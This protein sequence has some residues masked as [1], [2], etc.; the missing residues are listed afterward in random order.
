MEQYFINNEEVMFQK[1]KGFFLDN[2]PDKISIKVCTPFTDTN[3]YPDTQEI[4]SILEDCSLKY[5]ISSKIKSAT[6]KKSKNRLKRKEIYI[7]FDISNI[8]NELV[9]YINCNE[10][11]TRNYHNRLKLHDVELKDYT[12]NLDKKRMEHQ[13]DEIEGKVKNIY[14]QN[15]VSNIIFYEDDYTGKNSVPEWHTDNGCYSTVDDSLFLGITLTNPPNIKLS[16]MYIIVPLLVISEKILSNSKLINEINLIK[17]KISLLDKIKITFY[18][19]N[20]EEEYNVVGTNII[21]LFNGLMD[22]LTSIFLDKN[23][24]QINPEL[25]KMAPTNII[26]NV[27][28]VFYHKSPDLKLLKYDKDRK[29]SRCHIVYTVD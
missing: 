1:L 24:D 7:S 3:V 5:T 11:W 29:L 20:K 15:R 21:N 27:A 10:N 28:S 16:T 13:I 2:I 18:S 25:V 14:H 12:L 19:I 9:N 6:L 23:N 4:N 22:K 17:D 8:K 26:H